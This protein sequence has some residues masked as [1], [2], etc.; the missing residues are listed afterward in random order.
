MFHLQV[1]HVQST[2]YQAS[3]QTN[4]MFHTW[5]QLQENSKISLKDFSQQNKGWHLNITQPH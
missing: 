2:F 1:T 5:N 3:K 4:M